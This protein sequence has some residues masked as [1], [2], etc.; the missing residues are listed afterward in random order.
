MLGRGWEHCRLLPTPGFPL[1][2]FFPFFR[3][4][5]TKRSLCSGE[6]NSVNEP[7]AKNL[8]FPL[9]QHGAFEQRVDPNCEAWTSLEL[10]GA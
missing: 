5:S 3:F 4:S 1:L 7:R 8:I 10:N 9:L 6:R 2:F